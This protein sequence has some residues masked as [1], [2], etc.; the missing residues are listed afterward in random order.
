MSGGS[1]NYICYQIEEELVGHMEGKE[2]DDLMND[3]AT[4]AHDLEWYHS[5][6][7]NR[8]D[9]RESVR[10]FKEKWF[11]QSREERL[12]KYIEEAIQETKEE[13]L[14]MIGSDDK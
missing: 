11:K 12:R 10:K 7:T 8:D 6:D 3:I 2:L 4:L 13:L 9:Y 14:N 5:A 1:H